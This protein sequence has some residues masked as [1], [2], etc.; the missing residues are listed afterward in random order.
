MGPGARKWYQTD[1]EGISYHYHSKM[2]VVTALPWRKVFK[3]K[4]LEVILTCTTEL[5]ILRVLVP[6][7]I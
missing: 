7:Q 3:K 4:N 6:G 1:R 5:P 2:R